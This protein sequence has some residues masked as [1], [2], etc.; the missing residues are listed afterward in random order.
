VGYASQVWNERNGDCVGRLGRIV[1][2]VV[3]LALL[4]ATA[5]AA[6]FGAV[7]DLGYNV[8]PAGPPAVVGAQDEVP[9][10]NGIWVNGTVETPTAP[11]SSPTDLFTPQAISSTGVAVGFARN[12]MGYDVPAYWDSVHSA[13][14]VEVPLSGLSVN[15][16]PVTSGRLSGVDATGEAVGSVQNA[17]GA[18]PADFAGLSVGAS[19]GLPAGPAQV[20]TALG[21]SV[22]SLAGISAGWEEGADTN[23]MFF[24]YNRLSAARTNSGLV[25]LE[26]GPGAVAS[27]GLLTG[28]TNSSTNPTAEVLSPSGAT[29]VLQV[30]SGDG[31]GVYGLNSSGVVVGV[32]RT[33]GSTGVSWSAAGVMTPLL[34]EVS[35]N[36]PGF[37]ALYPTGID[38]TGDIDGTGELNG[39]SDGFLVRVKQIVPPIVNS[40]GDAAAANPSGGSCD[41]GRT[42]SASGQQ[43]PECTLRAAI[44]AVSSGQ[45]TTTQITFDF[46]PGVSG[47]IKLLSPLPSLTAAGAAIDGPEVEIDGTGLAAKGD[48]ITVQ[49]PE[50]SITGLD[51]VNCPNGIDLGPPGLDKVQGVVIGLDPSG[52]PAA[53]HSGVVVEPGSNGNLIG[54]TQANQRD[55]ISDQGYGV[56]VGGTGNLVQGDRLGTDVAGSGFVPDQVGLLVGGSRNTIGGRTTSPGTGPGNVI[57]AGHPTARGVYDLIVGG[58]SNTVAGNLIGTD[59]A[60]TTAYAPKSGYPARVGV[61]VAAPAAGIVIGG[62]AGYGNVIAGASGAQVELDGKTASGAQVLGNTIG[63]GIRGDSLPSPGATGVLDAAASSARIGASGEANSITGQKVGVA[64]STDS[65]AIN[66]TTTEIV[67]GQETEQTYVLGGTDTPADPTGASVKDNVIGPLPGGARAPADPEQIGVLD[68]DGESDLIGP[69]NIVSFNDVGV[70]L[71]RTKKAE[72][73]GNQ[74]GTD[75]GGLTALPNGIGLESVDTV[76]TEIGT[77]GLPDTISGNLLDLLLD[78]TGNVVEGEKIGLNT[79]GTAELRRFRGKIP[80]SIERA[81]AHRGKGGILVEGGAKATLIGGDRSGEGV[82]VGGTDGVGITTGG[83]TVIIGDRIGVSAGAH[84]ALPNSDNGVDA[85]GN[86]L[87]A[88]SVIANSDRHGVLEDGPTMV[89][90]T[91]IYDNRDGGFDIHTHDA[92]RPPRVL[93]ATNRA[94][95]TVIDAEATPGREWGLLELFA[96]RSC[97]AH[98]AGEKL[99]DSSVLKPN[100]HSAVAKVKTEPVG[101][102]ITALLTLTP[103][104]TALAEAKLKD[105]LVNG[106]TSTFSDCTTVKPR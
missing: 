53:G 26:S 48:C 33:N 1:I 58:A 32:L 72:V 74:I 20:V 6:G 66:Y 10:Q 12:A 64:I 102:A 81:V 94:G 34:S 54:G 71:K 90:A 23:G 91:P 5:A 37:T 68:E 87:I 96:S 104:D 77:A 62:G 39:Q 89:V 22:H 47:P 11:A 16:S 86:T 25:G 17:A 92:P 78:S 61:L 69:R 13:S 44:Q 70:E 84:K 60:G 106:R 2:V 57:A 14:F 67:D 76:K 45:A 36:A 50:V 30:P 18:T 35:A 19:G 3:A 15:G 21:G 88:G 63:A 95:H 80:A 93:A 83:T 56:E 101:T 65:D 7:V 103:R 79:R 52:T 98:G 99:L 31:A 75:K 38:D 97:Q 105:P 27:N 46:P 59:A 100:R 51:L 24:A 49:A 55:V 73:A 85:F 42:I 82:T 29:T 8:I 9:V 43:V 41:T 40:T 28:Y 4:P